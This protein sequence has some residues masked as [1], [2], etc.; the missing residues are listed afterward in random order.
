M[1]I[2]RA[3]DIR[4]VFGK[5]ITEQ[6]ALGIGKALGTILTGR[7][8]VCVGY[9]TRPSSVPLFKSFTAGLLSTGCDVIDLG[10]VSNPM[11]YFF[12]MKNKMFGCYITA[13]HN[14]TNWNGFKMIRQNGTSFI[15]EGRELERAYNLGKFK[16]GK[17]RMTKADAIGAYQEFMLS[18]FKGLKCKVVVDFLGGAGKMSEKLLK[19]TGLDVVPLHTLSDASLY[20]FHMLEPWGVLLDSA[21]KAVK[22]EKADF[23]VAFDCD[24][25]RSIFISPDGKYVDPSVMVGLFA[26]N[27]LRRK[28]KVIATFDCASEI[29]ELVKNL[30]GE[31]IWSRIGHSFIEERLVEEDALL[32]GEESSHYFFGDIYPFSDGAL[33]A[34]KLCSIIKETG[35]SFDQLLGEIDFH[36]VEKIYI[37]AKTDE[38]KDKT[39]DEMRLR[40][41]ESINIYDGFK[42]ILNE[43]EWIIVRA[44][45]TLPE[46]NLC[47][48][49]KSDK[50]RKEM[51]KKYS[52]EIRSLI[53]K[54]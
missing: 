8:K 48:E 41:P 50:R 49:A 43:T 32:A 6:V 18:K 21:K 9:D 20:G 51:I 29:R 10:L 3:Y 1:S 27:A 54:A 16:S 13:S 44:S 38:K 14:P 52:A 5:D 30:G 40:H 31:L 28:G 45:Q 4:G 22:E 34:L 25:D 12:S 26:K 11:T 17:G 7:G 19:K 36:P 46:V 39:V 2:F 42:I 47:M 15:E 23:G 35:K 53:H 37:N 24:A 33:S